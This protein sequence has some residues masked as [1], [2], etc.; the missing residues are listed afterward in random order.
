M[1]CLCMKSLAVIAFHILVSSTSFPRQS[2]IINATETAVASATGGTFIV[3]VGVV[4]TESFL[5]V[6]SLVRTWRGRK[7][8]VL[9]LSPRPS[10]SVPTSA[11]FWASCKT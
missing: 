5:L 11:S 8:L 10:T 2:E 1:V 7:P 9:G 4:W 6:C 3:V